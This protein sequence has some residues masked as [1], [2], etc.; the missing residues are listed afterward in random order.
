MD[1]FTF[2]GSLG[3]FPSLSDF[4]S[5]QFGLSDQQLIPSTTSAETTHV[6]D[7]KDVNRENSTNNQNPDSEIDHSGTSTSTTPISSTTLTQS[8]TQIPTQIQTQTQTQTQT[9]SQNCHTEVQPAFVCNTNDIP[10][11][12]QVGGV[13]K[14]TDLPHIRQMLHQALENQEVLE[15]ANRNTLMLQDTIP[16]IPASSGMIVP[17]NPQRFEKQELEEDDG[18]S[19]SNQNNQLQVKTEESMEVDDLLRNVGQLKDIA[20]RELVKYNPEMLDVNDAKIVGKHKFLDITPY[21]VLPQAEAARRFGIPPSTL[22]K[23]W[24]TAARKRKWPWRAV[25][26]IDKE[27]STI[28]QN[29]KSGEE[30]EPDIARRLAM[31]LCQRSKELTPV[32]IRM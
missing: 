12:A 5:F 10:L 25:A 2:S 22:S 8:Q 18:S 21:M 31:L 20:E 26:K 27:I 4:G 19:E 13:V 24:R 17:V 14:P 1:Q 30:L 7:E 16:R 6:Q 28:C 3:S 29:I 32:H 23:R 9:Q 15:R 11:I